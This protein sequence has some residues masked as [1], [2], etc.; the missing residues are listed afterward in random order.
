MFIL[1]DDNN[2]FTSFVCYKVYVAGWKQREHPYLHNT[3]HLGDRILCIG[4]TAVRTAAEAH[5][6][7]RAEDTLLVSTI[8]GC[9]LY[10]FS[11]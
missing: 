3:F 8:Y 6:V 5:A 2:V 11:K 4:G 1:N 7:I 9:E 10:L